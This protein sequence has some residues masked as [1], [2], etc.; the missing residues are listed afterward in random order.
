MDKTFKFNKQ[1]RLDLARTLTWRA[2]SEKKDKIESFLD[3]A[4]SILSE[5]LNPEPTKYSTLLIKERRELFSE[6]KDRALALRAALKALPKRERLEIDAIGKVYAEPGLSPDER[7]DKLVSVWVPNGFTPRDSNC[8]E[9]WLKN[10]ED[11]CLAV[12]GASDLLRP[13]RPKPGPQKEQEISIVIHLVTRYQV[14]VGDVSSSENGAFFSFLA[15]LG[16]MVS[17]EFGP[18]ILAQVLKAC[19][20][21]KRGRLG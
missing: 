14:V 11:I 19:P 1:Q 8:N 2:S 5:H 3:D 10:L 12:V 4:E 7:I 21:L 9:E 16:P 13:S 20:N 6:L 15:A 17:R 18:A